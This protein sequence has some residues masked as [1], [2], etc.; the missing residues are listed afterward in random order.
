ML[1]KLLPGVIFTTMF[2]VQKC[3]FLVQELAALI[4]LAKLTPGRLYFCSVKF[5]SENTEKN[6]FFIDKGKKIEERE[7][8]E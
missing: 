1:V 6:N 4:M 3:T 2:F 8:V 7:L 5:F